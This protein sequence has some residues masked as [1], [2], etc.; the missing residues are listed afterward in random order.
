MDD[1]YLRIE[2]RLFV[3]LKRVFDTV[4]R[5]DEIPIDEG[6]IDE[7]RHALDDASINALP[8]LPIVVNLTQ[9]TLDAILGCFEVGGEGA[10]DISDD[11]Y[12]AIHG[13]LAGS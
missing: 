1:V 13:L 3:M 10:E 4:A 2:P 8:G 6:I 5:D 7:A 11:D 12:E 9:D